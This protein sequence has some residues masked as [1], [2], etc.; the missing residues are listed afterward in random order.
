VRGL[1]RAPERNAIL[2]RIRPP[3]MRML[4]QRSPADWYFASVVTFMIPA[5]IQMVLLPYLLAIELRQPADRFGL[6][7]MF[8]QLPILIF[9]LFG[10][11]LADRVDPRRLLIALQAV[12][13]V[14]PLILAAALWRGQASEVLLL[15]YAVSWGLVSAFAMPARDGLLKRVAGERVQR[16]VTL[17]IGV[18]FGSQMLGQALGGAAQSLN[19]TA[20]LLLQCLVL[21]IGVFTASR[22]PKAAL[23]S[24]LPVPTPTTSSPSLWREFGAGLSLIY[25]DR[26][27]RAT[28]I[29]TCG[30][31]IFFGGV[32]VVLMPLIL[33]DLYV[34]SARD[35]AFGY[36][37][38][39]A[40]TLITIVTLTRM[41]GIR[42][43][44]R[45]LILSQ[46]AGCLM[47]A[48]LAFAP[49]KPAFYLCVFLWGMCGGVA[50]TMSRTIMQER[51]PASHQSRVMAAFSLATA[52][53]GPLGS[54]LLGYAVSLL[55]ARWAVFVPILGVLC[56]TG[57]AVLCDPIGRLQSQSR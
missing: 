55:G 34:G 3:E 15:L 26:S 7:L 38:F 40:G 4:N 54:L 17:A 25:A 46:F 45:A 41:G 10:G 28:Y 30:M 2:T 48:P 43:P 51:A 12:G 23:S 57:G 33:R 32:F 14:M 37:A 39:G 53:G 22:L 50:M 49:P 18:Q 36:L 5:G 6:T 27:M 52:G 8:G 9:L 13:I 35:I 56:A 44:G 19:A 47:L 29:L 21:A 11:W 20:L 42:L 31:G 16:M 1:D 24:A